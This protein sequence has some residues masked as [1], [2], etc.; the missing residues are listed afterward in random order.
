MNTTAAAF[1]LAL[2]PAPILAAETAEFLTIGPGARELAM[3]SAG[4]AVSN[5][6]DALWW[7]PAGLARLQ[8][9]EAMIDDAELPQGA[10][11]DDVYAASPTRFGAVALGGTY[12]NQSVADGRDAYGHPV[13]GYGAWDGA[14]SAGAGV[15]TDWVDLG[16]SVKY[17]RSDIAQAQAQ[18]AAV[19]LGARRAFGP[20][21][22][23]AGVRNLGPG[24]KFAG[25]TD[26]LPLRL[27]AGAAWSF[28]GGHALSAQFTN[29]PRGG[30]SVEGVGG[31]FQAFSG[32]FLRAGYS[33]QAQT[34]AGTGLDA[35]TGV[36]FGFG[37]KQP[38][39]SVDYAAAPMG[40]LGT[41]QRFS[42]AYRW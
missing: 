4:T 6:A 25:E 2:L 36:T 16:A 18:S 21:A 1:L 34:N 32:L 13:G 7:N 9:G 15:K 35:V 39:W 22:L 30:G 40:E 38:R 8:G 31:E 26:S 41:T 12:L 5:G 42:A 23:A 17:I 24:M 33:T 11:I 3:G 14:V 10:R 37:F 20:L 19:D 27:D 28:P 29:A